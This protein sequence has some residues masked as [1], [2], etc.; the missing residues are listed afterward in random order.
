MLC[1]INY[2]RTSKANKDNILLPIKPALEKKIPVKNEN[3][4]IQFIFYTKKNKYS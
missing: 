1:I 4:S 2:I 3:Y